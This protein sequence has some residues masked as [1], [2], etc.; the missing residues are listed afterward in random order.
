MQCFVKEKEKAKQTYFS[1]IRDKGRDFTLDWH[2]I[3]ILQ[4]KKKTHI[5]VKDFVCP[6]LLARVKT[7]LFL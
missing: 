1:S 4:A 2:I 5:C 3:G 6:V 7:E